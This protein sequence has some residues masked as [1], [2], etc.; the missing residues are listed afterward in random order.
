MLKSLETPW[1]CS[2]VCII[3]IIIFISVLHRPPRAWQ[4]YPGHWFLRTS[5]L[6]LVGQ[7][8][9]EGKKK[10]NM[11]DDGQPRGAGGS[12]QL[13]GALM[14]SIGTIDAAE[15][16]PISPSG[17]PRVHC[18]HSAAQTAQDRTGA[19]IQLWENMCR[20]AFPVSSGT[21]PVTAGVEQGE[22]RHGTRLRHRGGSWI[23][24]TGRHQTLS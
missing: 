13:L 22:T 3:I 1:G 5:I 10:R 14:T 2:A 18:C 7:V 19:L 11:H 20:R 16:N 12:Q 15:P 8:K 23:C 4:R 24:L 9:E 17:T 6:R 21:F